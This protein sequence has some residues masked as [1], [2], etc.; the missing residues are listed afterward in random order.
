MIEKDERPDGLQPC[1]RQQAT[2]RETPEVARATFDDTLDARQARHRSQAR[3]D[4]IVRLIEAEHGL[5]LLELTSTGNV[6]RGEPRKIALPAA[7][8]MTPCSR[9]SFLTAA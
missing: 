4:V 3:L 9:L 7:D 5:A 8:D 6:A 2:H 1:G